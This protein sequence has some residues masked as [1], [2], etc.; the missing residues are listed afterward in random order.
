MFRAHPVIL[1]V[2]GTRLNEVLSRTS[3][4]L[5]VLGPSVHET[6]VAATT[7]RPDQPS[8]PRLPDALPD[9]LTRREAEI[10]ILIAQ[11]KTNSGIAVRLYLSPHTVRSHINHIFAKTRS[12][13]R[14]AA[15]CYAHQHDLA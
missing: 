9:G 1:R 15:I 3:C 7:P 6:L 12:P 5:S 10:L 13:D 2:A 14:P 11:G 8:E 4:G